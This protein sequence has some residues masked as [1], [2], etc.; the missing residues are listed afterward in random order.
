MMK[1]TARGFTLIEL[2]VTMSIIGILFG[3]GF[4]KYNEFNRRQILAQAAQELKN[5]LRF[6]QA[7]ALAGEKPSGCG[8]TSLSGHR[9]KF[10]VDNKNYK[11][12][13][14]CGSE[15]DVKTGLSLGLNVSKVSGPSSILFKVLAQGVE[16]AG[17]ITLRFSGVDDETVTV[18][19]TGDIK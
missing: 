3:I 14:V 12:V 16:G 13:A 19:K 2:L 17:I 5:N 15:V 7:K 11:I 10:A 6:A 9:L 18:T 1:K 8:S 4:A